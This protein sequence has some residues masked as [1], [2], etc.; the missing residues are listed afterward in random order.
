MWIWGGGLHNVGADPVHSRKVHKECDNGVGEKFEWQQK[1]CKIEKLLDNFDDRNRESE[2]IWRL[3]NDKTVNNREISR[4]KIMITCCMFYIDTV[5]LFFV[6][7]P[8]Q[9]PLASASVPLSIASAFSRS[10][11]SPLFSWFT[12]ALS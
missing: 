8:L 12:H 11:S 4:G 6:N 7:C 2:F 9:L 3:L 5:I 10:I 1:D